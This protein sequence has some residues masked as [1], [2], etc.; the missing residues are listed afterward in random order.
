M[1]AI[2]SEDVTSLLAP[3][4]DVTDPPKVRIII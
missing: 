3:L 4:C 1:T 2:G